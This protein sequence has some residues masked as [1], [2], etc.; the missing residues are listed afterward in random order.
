MSRPDKTII[1]I[2]TGKTTE[3]QVRFQ[4]EKHLRTFIICSQL[5]SNA[6]KPR[7][8]AVVWSQSRRRARL[9]ESPGEGLLV[10]DSFRGFATL[11]HVLFYVF[12]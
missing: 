4:Y 3:E 1:S 7:F 2:Q 10:R 9:L 11:D 6:A 5:D 12:C 8:R